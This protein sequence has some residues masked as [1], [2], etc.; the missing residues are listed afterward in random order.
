MRMTR[1]TASAGAGVTEITTSFG[2]TIGNDL[3]EKGDSYSFRA[4]SSPS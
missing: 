4:T 3:P 2:D 1:K